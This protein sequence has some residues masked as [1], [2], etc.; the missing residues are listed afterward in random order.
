VAHRAG[1]VEALLAALHQL[2]VTGTEYRCPSS[3]PFCRCCSNRCGTE[4]DASARKFFARRIAP[5]RAT[6]GSF[7]RCFRHF[8]ADRH[9]A[10]TGRRGRDHRQ[11]IERRLRAHFHLAH[12]VRENFDRCRCCLS[13]ETEIATSAIAGEKKMR[14][15]PRSILVLVHDGDVLPAALL[16]QLA[17]F[18][19]GETRIARFD[20]EEKS[21]VRRAA[22]SVPVENRMIPA[23]QSVH[24][25]AAKNAANA[26]K[27]TVSSNM[28]GKNAGT[29]FQ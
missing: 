17:R 20:R 2:G 24:D 18:D 25:L 29:V 10:A 23:R 15:K 16:E 11:K 28:I 9:R 7:G 26:E 12:H 27:R 14:K 19:F 3:R 13:A 4:S 5:H 8:V 1:D 22:E 6:S 21:V